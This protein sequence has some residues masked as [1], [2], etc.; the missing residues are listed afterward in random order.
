MIYLGKGNTFGP[1]HW[2]R[3]RVGS[4]GVKVDGHVGLS[5]WVIVQNIVGLDTVAAAVGIVGLDIVAA[6]VGIAVL[7]RLSNRITLGGPNN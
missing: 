2:V 4:N 7:N 3:A 6:A 5:D 1:T